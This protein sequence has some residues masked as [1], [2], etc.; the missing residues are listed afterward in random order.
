MG[1]RRWYRTAPPTTHSL[2]P[3]AA[4]AKPSHEVKSQAAMTERKKLEP[5][6]PTPFLKIK[7]VR[8]KI[9]PG[10]CDLGYP[11]TGR[12]ER[13][14]ER[15]EEPERIPTS[16]YRPRGER[17]RKTE[18]SGCGRD[19]QGERKSSLVSPKNFQKFIETGCG[20]RLEALAIDAWAR[21][22]F[23]PAT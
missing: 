3:A 22:R 9:S 8:K 13:E 1:M 17:A 5:A 7:P 20:G 2:I 21:L 4:S 23:P 18:L 15:D 12:G 6:L 14:R 16:F 10:G 19:E 11:G